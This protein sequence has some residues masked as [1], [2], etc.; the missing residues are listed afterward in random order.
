MSLQDSIY[1]PIYLL[2]VAITIFIGI[3][4]WMS[5]QAN[6]SIMVAGGPY[7]TLINNAMNQIQAGLDSFD[8]VFPI[9]IVGLLVVS[10]AFAFRTGASMVYAFLAIIMWGLALLISA[11]LANIF[12]TFVV[13]FPTVSAT[14]PLITYIMLN[15][16]WLVLAWLFLLSAV[17]FTRNKREDQMI[18]SAEMAYGNI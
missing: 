9:L 2:T 10:L 6:M 1:V 13:N 18:A 17:M 4:V 7:E 11:I 3:F 8:Y 15:I 14:F 12:S 5:F 16:K